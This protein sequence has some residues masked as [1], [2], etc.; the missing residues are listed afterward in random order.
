MDDLFDKYG[1]R[2]CMCGSGKARY[3]LTDAAGVFC[4]YV[5]V[6]CEAAKKATYDP[7]IFTTYYDADKSDVYYPNDY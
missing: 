2:L 1:N 6:K 3:D 5:C 7:R 4:G